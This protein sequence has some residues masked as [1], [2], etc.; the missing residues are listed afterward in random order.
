MKKKD[1]WK[2]VNRI[3]NEQV[4]SQ[5]LVRLRVKVHHTIEWSM[6]DKTWDDVRHQVWWEVRHLAVIKE[7]EEEEE[8]E[9]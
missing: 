1:N 4:T 7:E 3:I 9:K 2:T 5:I 8:E 6:R